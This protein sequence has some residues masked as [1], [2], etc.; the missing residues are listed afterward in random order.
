MMHYSGNE[1]TCYLI[2]DLG[3]PCMGTWPGSMIP[4]KPGSTVF[5]RTC[6]MLLE[7]RMPSLKTDL[8]NKA[9]QSSHDT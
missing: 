8:P 4:P 7:V 6:N 2:R 3:E 1:L 5:T 9:F